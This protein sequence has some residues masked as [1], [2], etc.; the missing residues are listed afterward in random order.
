MNLLS[1]RSNDGLVARLSDEPGRLSR[2]FAD[3]PKAVILKVNDA[4]N[5]AALV[6]GIH[7][8]AKTLAIT[9][10]ESVKKILEVYPH[11]PVEDLVVAIRMASFGEL[12]VENQLT[13]ISAYNV[14]GWYKQFREDK[15]HLTTMP[16]AAA[17]N[18]M[19]QEPS[20]SEKS[21]IV[22]RAFVNFV[23]DPQFND[24]SIDFQI[25]KLSQIGAFTPSAEQKRK[26]Y[27]DE[28]FKATQAPPL[29]FLKDRDKRRDV[30]AYQDKYQ[31]E[32]ESI[33]FAE[34][35]DNA[36][37]RFI[38]DRAKRTM[39]MDFMKNSNSD[40]LIKLF[41]EKFGKEMD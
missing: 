25:D 10:T 15:S 14:Y 1:T 7:P 4:L 6:M 24:L 27:F 29:E 23:T 18:I 31:L 19:S 39:V 38:I 17:V 30:L 11:A 37:H 35:I 34:V 32:G 12:R 36:L 40:D 9:A 41:D 33:K 5:R 3:D 21:K 16:P 20:E 28:A 26:Y 22:R 13:T 8:D 2:E